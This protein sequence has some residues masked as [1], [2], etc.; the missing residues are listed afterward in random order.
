M[1]LLMKA[2]LISHHW[3]NPFQALG[4]KLRDLTTSTAD[5]VSVLCWRPHRFVALEP[6][7]EIVRPHQ[8]ALDQHFE[9]PIYGRGADLVTGVKQATLD[10]I[11]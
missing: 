1:P 7:A 3:E 2:V 5:Q 9:R 4:R 8:A 10:T 11:D 6:F